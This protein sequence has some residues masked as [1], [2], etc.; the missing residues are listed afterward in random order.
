[1]K[2]LVETILNLANR[3]QFASLVYTTKTKT[4]KT[5]KIVDGGEKS[6][7]TVILGAK[8]G[9]LLEKSLLACSLLNVVEL[10]KDKA[11][12]EAIMAKAREDVET[13]LRKSIAAHKLG[14][15]NSDYTKKNQYIPLA[16][17]LNINETDNSLQLFGLIH[18][19]VVLE[20][21]VHKYVNSAIET[22]AKN[23]IRKSLPIGKFREFAIDPGQ[24]QVAK[25]DGET[26][27]LE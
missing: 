17:G 6:R 14:T 16:N 1:M 25:L 27:V 3:A 22:I 9:E 7:F 26:L 4:D 12:D 2:S 21:G 5:G 19:K 8:Y 23:A 10:A 24:V 20:P 13:S 18:S 11:I 15:Q